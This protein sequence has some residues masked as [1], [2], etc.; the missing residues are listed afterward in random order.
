ML[1]STAH[2]VQCIQRS[3]QTKQI[4][5]TKFRNVLLHRKVGST[6]SRHIPTL[7]QLLTSLEPPKKNKDGPPKKRRKNK[8]F[9]GKTTKFLHVS[10]FAIGEEVLQSLRDT[11][12]AATAGTAGALTLDKISSKHTAKELANVQERKQKL[13][14]KKEK[15]QVRKEATRARRQEKRAT[16][17]EKQRAQLE[18]QRA[19]EESRAQKDQEE[20]SEL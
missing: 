3:S 6:Q 13:E 18:K 5:R 17:R 9:I 15:L 12:Q 19:K 16:R 14:E 1:N 11:H 2:F 20:G 7:Q 4:V 10:R 8:K